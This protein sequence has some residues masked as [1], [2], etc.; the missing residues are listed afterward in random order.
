MSFRLG[1]ISGVDI[2]VNWTVL[3]I[4]WLI[5]WSVATAALP[6]SYPGHGVGQY[7][8]AGV[9]VALLFFASLLAHE[10]AH[11][12]V[13]QRAEWRSPTSPCGCSVAC[14]AS[15]AR[16]TTPPTKFRITAGRT[17][18]QPGPR[19]GVHGARRWRWPWPVSPSSPSRSRPC[20]RCSTWRSGS[21]TCCRRSR[22]TAA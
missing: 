1:Q 8:A 9:A 7:W 2:G 12:L 11:S 13:A 10:L 5:C 6:E 19:A 20:S 15:R 16:P 21:S 3:V 22:S 14:H 17:P 4:A 18:H